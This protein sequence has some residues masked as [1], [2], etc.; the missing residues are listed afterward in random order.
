MMYEKAELLQLK[1]IFNNS[2]NLY[3]Y[4]TDI[5]DIDT[6]LVTLRIFDIRICLNLKCHIYKNMELIQLDILNIC[7]F[8][9]IGLWC[10]ILSFVLYIIFVQY[11]KFEIILVQESSLNHIIIILAIGYFKYITQHMQAVS[12]TW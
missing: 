6:K 12:K 8:V 7:I 11:I 1:K 4:K 10:V 3:I 5:A 2:Y 9:L